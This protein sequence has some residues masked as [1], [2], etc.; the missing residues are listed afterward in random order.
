MVSAK[1]SDFMLKPL[2][3]QVVLKKYEEENKTSS[4][5]ILATENK[6]LP[7]VDGTDGSEGMMETA[8]GVS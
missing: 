7:S 3:N 2:R 5:I 8:T 4:G 1:R 6:K